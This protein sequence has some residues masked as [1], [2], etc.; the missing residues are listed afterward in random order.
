MQISI[1]VYLPSFAILGSAAA[2]LG[3]SVIT[4]K[5]HYYKITEVT[6]R[7]V[8]GSTISAFVDWGEVGTESDSGDVIYRS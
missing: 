3:G 1:L 7:D 4:G 5:F 6:S 2:T 8:G